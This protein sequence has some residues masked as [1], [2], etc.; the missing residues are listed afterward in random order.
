MFQ[1]EINT[2]LTVAF[3]D[4]TELTDVNDA[5]RHRLLEN[6]FTDNV[7]QIKRKKIKMWPR[8]GIAAAIATIIVSA[9]IWFVNK[10]KDK[11]EKETLY[12]QDIAPGKQ[13]AT[14]TLANGKKIRL[15]EAAN[16]QLAK[17]SGVT[18]TKAANGQLI[19]QIENSNANE[20]QVNMLS[21]TNGETYQVRLPDGSDVWLNS[22]SSLTYKASLNEQGRRIVKLTGEAYFQVAKDKSHPFVVKTASQEVEVLG[23]HFNVNSYRDE[24]AIATTL[25]EGS[26]KVTA[27]NSKQI[28]K[29]GE[30]AINYGSNIK[31]THVDVDKIIDWKDGDFNLDNVDFKTAMRKIAR[32]YN[33]EV[34]YDTSL[35]DD[36]EAGGWISR[37][38]TLSSVLKS[39]ERTGQVRFKLEGRKLYVS[40]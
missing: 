15:T 23:T 31:V 37:N 10:P 27:G 4:Q 30:Q 33:V 39:I 24:P 28:I 6:I 13:G 5:V 32:W 21:T 22:A 26:V 16:G 11:A 29:P 36:I 12:T 14:L 1:Q 3:Q 40:K 35:P 34:T 2:L 18:I 9:A 38:N 7:V 19:Y 25:L 20:D 17:Q 8:I